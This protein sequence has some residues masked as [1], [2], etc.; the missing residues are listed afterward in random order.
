MIYIDIVYLIFH[1]NR[2]R[3]DESDKSY[4]LAEM[5]PGQKLHLRTYVYLATTRKLSM[6]AS[7]YAVQCA[8]TSTLRY[9]SVTLK[10][11]TVHK[12]TQKKQGNV[13]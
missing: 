3:R 10:S 13:F 11:V 5:T 8:H 12:V 4:L 9:W 7:Y 2:R 1:D 6:T